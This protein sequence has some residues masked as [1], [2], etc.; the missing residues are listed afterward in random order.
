MLV[1]LQKFTESIPALWQQYEAR[2]N[3]VDEDLGQA[4]GQLAK[5]SEEFQFSVKEFVSSLDGSF[6]NALNRLSG[7]VKELQEEREN[8]QLAINSQE[9]MGYVDAD[10]RIA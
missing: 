1:D 7:A 6:S 5:G 8:A 3:K 2:F 4:F 10:T 9:N